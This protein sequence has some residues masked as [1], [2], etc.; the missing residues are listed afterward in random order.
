M[1]I[2]F[3]SRNSFSIRWSP[4][5]PTA[6]SSSMPRLATSYATAGATAFAIDASTRFG[7]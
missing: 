2:A 7:R 5:A 3:T 6:P 4:R 1:S